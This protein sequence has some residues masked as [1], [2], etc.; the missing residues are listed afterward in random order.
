MQMSCFHFV[1]NQ[2][3]QLA[4]AGFLWQHTVTQH[5]DLKPDTVEQLSYKTK[6]NLYSYTQ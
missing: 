4:S 2:S 5:F 6:T 3:D 1:I